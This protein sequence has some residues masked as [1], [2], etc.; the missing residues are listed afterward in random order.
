MD[1]TSSPNS[2]IRECD[3]HVIADV[4]IEVGRCPVVLQSHPLADHNVN[5]FV[6]VET[7]QEIVC[8]LDSV[9]IRPYLSFDTGI[10]LLVCL[11]FVRCSRSLDIN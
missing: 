11:P 9:T 2:A 5:N 3:V 4:D 10:L 1:G 7:Q 6:T 8:C